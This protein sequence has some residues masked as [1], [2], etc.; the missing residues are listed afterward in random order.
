MEFQKVGEL[1]P[2]RKATYWLRS[3]RCFRAGSLIPGGLRGT[4]FANSSPDGQRT[5]KLRRGHC[6][7]V[8]EHPQLGF[9][10]GKLRE[11]AIHAHRNLCVY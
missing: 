6:N 8:R 9:R 5:T 7:T 4:N 10:G 3:N 1:K 2:A 11:A